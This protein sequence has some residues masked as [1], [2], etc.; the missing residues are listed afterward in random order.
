MPDNEN[1]SEAFTKAN[2]NFDFIAAQ[3]ADVL[4]HLMRAV[5]SD[6][7]TSGAYHAAQSMNFVADLL[8]KT[9]EKFGFY[10]L[11]LKALEEF[12]DD[13]EWGSSEHDIV[14]A[15]NRGIKYIVERSCSDNAARGRA[16]RRQDEFL[17]AVKMIEEMREYRRKHPQ[18]SI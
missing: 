6:D 5:S 13:S 16:S 15:A 17:T 3:F 14:H 2:A 9:E 7:P 11:F 1:F 8:S 12:R 4:R 18:T 10:H